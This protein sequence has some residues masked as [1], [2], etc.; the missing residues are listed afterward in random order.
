[1]ETERN[2]RIAF[3]VN[4]DEKQQIEQIAAH[5]DLSVSDYIRFVALNAE[6]M[7]PVVR[8]RKRNEYKTEK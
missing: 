5:Y 1:M 4:A 2:D 7:T 8:T 6:I 3:R